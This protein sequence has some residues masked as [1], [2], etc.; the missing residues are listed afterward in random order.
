MVTVVQISLA[1]TASI[2]LPLQ[3]QMQSMRR[4]QLTC[5]EHRNGAVGSVVQKRRDAGLGTKRS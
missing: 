1:Q 4:R 5:P 2:H 3:M